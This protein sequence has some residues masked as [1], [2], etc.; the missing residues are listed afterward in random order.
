[1]KVFTDSSY[2]NEMLNYTSDGIFLQVGYFLRFYEVITLA[3]S[4]YEK[5]DDSIGPNSNILSPCVA[6]GILFT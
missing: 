4:H 5:R 2:F 3:L 6:V 1:M